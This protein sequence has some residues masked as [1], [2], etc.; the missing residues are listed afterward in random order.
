MPATTRIDWSGYRKSGAGASSRRCERERGVELGA[1]LAPALHVHLEALARQARAQPVVGVHSEEGRHVEA[2][3]EVSV[4]PPARVHVALAPGRVGDLG[5]QRLHVLALTVEA[6]VDADRVE[7][8]PERAHARQQPHR[9]LRA[10]ARPFLHRVEHGLP[11]R[12]LGRTHVVLPAEPRRRGAA[13]RPESDAV[14][15]LRQLVQ[16]Q[17]AEEDP[18]AELVGHRLMAAVAH[19]ALVQRT[20]AH[21]SILPKRSHTRSAETTP[22]SWKP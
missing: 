3:G 12:Y 17:I 15:H 4:E 16:I 10:D 2:L 20:R 11:Q 21:T 22:S 1:L 6:V 8:V 9:A 13:G 18:I 7:Q 5:G 19:P 14:E